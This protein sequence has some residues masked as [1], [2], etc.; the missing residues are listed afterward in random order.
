MLDIMWKERWDAAGCEGGKEVED[1]VGGPSPSEDASSSSPPR[2][3]MKRKLKNHRR[4]LH[5]PDHLHMRTPW[6]P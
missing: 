3:T 6:Y 1:T 2:V 4:H 5:L